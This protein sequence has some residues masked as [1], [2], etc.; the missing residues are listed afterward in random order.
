MKNLSQ[1]RRAGI[2][3][4]PSQ[5]NRFGVNYRGVNG[6]DSSSN[7]RSNSRDRIP[8][9]NNYTKVMQRISPMKAQEESVKPTKEV[10][11]RLYG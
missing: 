9:V 5:P 1:E 8:K 6:Q 2:K 10:F 11:N 4:S 3:V 7:N